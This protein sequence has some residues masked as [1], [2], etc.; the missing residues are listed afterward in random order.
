MC[1]H[2]LWWGVR[3]ELAVYVL[4]CESSLTR[5][6][7]KDVS[8][9]CFFPSLCCMNINWK[10]ATCKHTCISVCTYSCYLYTGRYWDIMAR[11]QH[12]YGRNVK[13]SWPACQVILMNAQAFLHFM[14]FMTWTVATNVSCTGTY[15]RVHLQIH[16]SESRELLTVF[17]RI[18]IGLVLFSLLLF[19][20]WIL[21]GSQNFRE[22]SLVWCLNFTVALF[23]SFF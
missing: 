9:E 6:E 4:E 17:S 18:N 15:G 19:C 2:W 20:K 16:S 14:R 13:D 5:I 8:D 11:G 21:N 23:R 22:R 7:S 3:V 10:A 1:W 12:V